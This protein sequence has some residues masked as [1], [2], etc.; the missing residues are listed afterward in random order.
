MAQFSM[1]SVLRIP[2]RLAA[3]S[4]EWIRLE[5]K[6]LE[7][8]SYMHLLTKKVNTSGIYGFILQFLLK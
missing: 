7:P 5:L 2:Y 1:C 6:P 8:S 4:R 3:G